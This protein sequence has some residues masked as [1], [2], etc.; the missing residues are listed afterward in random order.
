[1]ND[2]AHVIWA[3]SFSSGQ[4]KYQFTHLEQIEVNS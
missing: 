2:G 4:V 1:M 3:S